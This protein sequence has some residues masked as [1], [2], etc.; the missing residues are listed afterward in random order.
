M[1]QLSAHVDDETAAKVD[2]FESAEDCD[3]KSDAVNRL[4][5][6][7]LRSKGYVSVGG[8]DMAQSVARYSLVVAI[9]WFGIW[10]GTPVYGAYLVYASAGMIAVAWSMM[11]YAAILKNG[12]VPSSLSDVRRSVRGWLS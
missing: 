9:A 4:L 3:S 7:G 2:E 8:A 10:I 5:D 11:G 12:G 6:E 1:P